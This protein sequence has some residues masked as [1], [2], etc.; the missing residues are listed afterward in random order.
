[1]DDEKLRGKMFSIKIDED[2]KLVLPQPYMAEDLTALVRENLDH[3]KHWVPWATDDYSTEKSMEWIQMTLREFASD[4]PFG[5]VIVFD[6]KFA[7]TIGFHNLDKKNFSAEVGYWIAKEFE[8][9]GI[10]TR[11]CRVLIEYLFDKIQLNRLQINCNVENVKSRSIPE[12]LG[13][14]L[15]GIHRQAEFLNDRFGDWAVYAMLR[16]EWREQN[17]ECGTDKDADG[18]RED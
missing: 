17:G 16:E 18:N 15:E 12:R 3:L 11:S 14:K 8:G 6:N 10:I 1:M 13:F 2:L 9:R 5:A 4:G 7:G